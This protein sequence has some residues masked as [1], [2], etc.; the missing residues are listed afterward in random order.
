MTTLPTWEE[1]DAVFSRMV[2][3]SSA[4]VGFGELRMDGRWHRRGCT[5]SP[6]A[7]QAK[8]RDADAKWEI[9]AMTESEREMC[10]THC[11][12]VQLGLAGLDGT[13]YEAYHERK[14]RRL[15]GQGPVDRA[16]L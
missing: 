1:Y 10:E 15:A 13:A 2:R 6:N 7:W 8:L 11:S 3:L 14:A 5:A 12:A 9:A 4:L 16:D